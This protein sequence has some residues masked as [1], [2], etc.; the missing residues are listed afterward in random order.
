MN[1]KKGAEILTDQ[2]F[3]EAIRTGNER[4]FELLFRQQYSPLCQY[5]FSFLK[6]WDDA[7]EVV[8]AMFLAFWEKRDSLVITT[9]LKSYLYRAVHN[10]CL[11]RIKHLSVQAEYQSYVQADGSDV[12]QSPVQELMASELDIQ[13]QRAIE[14][15][16]E[17]CRLIFMMSR[18][19]ELKYQEI[20]DQL[21][22]SIKTV[23]N[24]IGKALRILRTELADYLP[25]LILLGIHVYD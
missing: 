8:Q 25:L 23:E 14:R 17:Q 13:L 2:Q 16:P 7:E 6:D 19:E 3:L 11:N 22:L 10:R 21:G 24:Q 20:A 1:D 4:T 9:S 12:Y 15:L 5:G 18:F